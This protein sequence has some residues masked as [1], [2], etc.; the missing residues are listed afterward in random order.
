MRLLR[1]AAV[2]ISLIVAVNASAGHRVPKT[3]RWPGRVIPYSIFTL[4]FEKFEISLINDSIE[5]WNT[6]LGHK[7]FRPATD[8]DKHVLS[9]SRASRTGPNDSSADHIGFKE[10]PQGTPIAVQGIA[11]R[12]GIAVSQREILHEL[13]HVLGLLHEH[14][15]EDAEKFITVSGPSAGSAF[16]KVMQSQFGPTEHTEEYDLLSI[17]HYESSADCGKEK[18]FWK[19]KS[20]DG[21]TL[22]KKLGVPNEA[23]IDARLR[24]CVLTHNCLTPL[25][26]RTAKALY[27]LP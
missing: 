9:I 19:L 3:K 27:D 12:R 20:P 17:M 22:A 14:E 7:L 21:T 6:A 23:A 1:H 5:T 4:D 26:I 13:G 2:T 8:T 24:N 18:C 16:K 10:F 25:D 15:R 11:L